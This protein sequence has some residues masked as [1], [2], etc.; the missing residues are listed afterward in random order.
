MIQFASNFCFL[1]T[2]CAKARQIHNNEM[3]RPKLKSVINLSLLLL[4]L[5]FCLA[6]IYFLVLIYLDPTCT[7]FVTL[8]IS[9]ERE[10]F[11]GCKNAVT[12]I[13]G[14]FSPLMIR[15]SL[16]SYFII[17]INWES[18]WNISLQRWKLVHVWPRRGARMNFG[19]G[20]KIS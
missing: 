17:T 3:I 4:L 15:Q 11:N 16:W 10:T 9:I 19:E 2:L 8:A 18:G 6:A 7:I 13:C 1:D 14:F 20:N 12:E 5:P